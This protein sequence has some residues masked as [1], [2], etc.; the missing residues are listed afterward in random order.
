MKYIEK[1]MREHIMPIPF[2]RYQNTSGCSTV[3]PTLIQNYEDSKT[4][5]EGQPHHSGDFF[6]TLIQNYEDSKTC[7]ERQPCPNTA[8]LHP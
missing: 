6:L 7:C 4:C 2:K 8:I 5:C 1:Y 3:F